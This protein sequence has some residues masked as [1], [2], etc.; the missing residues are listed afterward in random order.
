MSLKAGSSMD[1]KNLFEIIEIKNLTGNAPLTSSKKK[2]EVISCEQS[3]IT[4]F[5]ENAK[6]A[7][8]HLISLDAKIY[9]NSQCF[10][11]QGTGKI[12]ELTALENSTF[13]MKI[14]MTQFDKTLWGKFI[15][16]LAS[17]QKRADEILAVM[18]GEDT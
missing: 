15:S 17:T 3:E 16:N 1:L 9:L 2:M 11:F 7:L 5:V 4:L 13:K 6:C 8:D 14:K 18:K 12:I 10:D